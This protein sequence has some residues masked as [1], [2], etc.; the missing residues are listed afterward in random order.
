MQKLCNNLNYRFFLKISFPLAFSRKRLFFARK[1]SMYRYL[2]NTWHLS[3]LALFAYTTVQSVPYYV[4]SSPFFCIGAGNLKGYC[5]EKSMFLSGS[6]NS[7]YKDLRIFQNRVV[8]IVNKTSELISRNL[9][10]YRNARHFGMRHWASAYWRVHYATSHYFTF[11][12]DGT[13]SFNAMFLIRMYPGFFADPDPDF[14]IPDP[15]GF[16]L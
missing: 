5:H 2:S 12:R 14:K 7:F 8:T 10:P 1:K 3:R 15:S 4:S 9:C 6:G 11:R 13:L 16:W